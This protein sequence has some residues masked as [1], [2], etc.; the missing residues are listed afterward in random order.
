MDTNLNVGAKKLRTVRLD[1]GLLSSDFAASLGISPASLFRYE[2]GHYPL[3][4][5][6]ELALDGFLARRSAE[7]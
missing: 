4:L 6:I 2:N 1:S 5:K 7:P 3:P